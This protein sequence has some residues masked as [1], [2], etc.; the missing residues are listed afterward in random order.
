M[1]ADPDIPAF[2]RRDVRFG[3][4]ADM[5]DWRTHVRCHP[6]S[7]PQLAEP[8]KHELIN[9]PSG[10]LLESALEPR[11]ALSRRSW[12]FRNVP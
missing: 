8:I 1:A 9:A 6:G 2:H 4:Q 10:G 12:H 3:S 11:A 7:G 5:A